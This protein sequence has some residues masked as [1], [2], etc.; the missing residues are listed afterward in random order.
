[1]RDLASLLTVGSSLLL[2]A[3]GCRD[4]TVPD[5]RR[6]PETEI[7]TAQSGARD[8]KR[9]SPPGNLRI[10]DVGAYSVALAWNASTDNSGILSYRVHQS[11]GYEE[12][13]GQT[14]T[15]FTWTSHLDPRQTYSFYVYAVDG[16]GNVS[17]ASNTVTATLP[18]D[19]SP[20][21]APVLTATDVGANYIALSWSAADDDPRLYYAITL[22]G[23]AD[24]NGATSNTSRTYYLL[25]PATT[26]TFTARARDRGGNWS[27]V[28]APLA[29]TTKPRDAS[30]TVAPSAPTNVF[31]GWYASGDT[32]FEVTWTASTD[33]KDPQSLIRYDIFVNGVLSDVTVGTTRSTNYGIVGTNRIEVFAVDAAGNRSPAGST[34]LVIQM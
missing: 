23:S 7:A 24:P 5:A 6:L 13:V 9:P 32:E 1:M 10:T 11:Q 17:A 22:D 15:T 16:A 31:A 19:V 18:P 2:L 14:A 25:A 8:A 30:D 29:V 20:P 4:T 28:S 33:D 27:P 26:Y 3:A 21:A 12:T 34:T